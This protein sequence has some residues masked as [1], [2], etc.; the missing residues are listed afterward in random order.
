[1]ATFSVTPSNLLLRLAIAP[2][3]I[4]F[5]TATRHVVRYEGR[6]PPMQS[7]GGTLRALDARVAY[8]MGAPAYR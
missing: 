8:A 2:L 3:S 6:E 1:M 7:A 5:D 4:T